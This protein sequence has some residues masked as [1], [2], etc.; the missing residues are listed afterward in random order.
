MNTYTYEI[1]PTA[2]VI[3]SCNEKC[4]IRH[5]YNPVSLRSRIAKL[6]RQFNEFKLSPIHLGDVFED[7]V[8]TIDK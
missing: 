2:T 3:I 7:F 4:I 1:V 8:K 5:I 6:V